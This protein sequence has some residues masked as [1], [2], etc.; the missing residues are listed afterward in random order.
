MVLPRVVCAIERT[1][2]PLKD[3]ARLAARIWLPA[4]AKH[5]PVPAILEYLSYR[6]RHSTFKRD[7]LTH[8]YLAGYGYAGV[9]VDIGGSGELDSLLSDEYT[10]QGQGDAPEIIAWLVEQSWCSGAV[11]T[12]GISWGEFNGVHHRGG[13]T[14]GGIRL[15]VILPDGDVPRPTPRALAISLLVPEVFTF[16]ICVFNRLLLYLD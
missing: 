15:G 8:P 1:L 10:K 6:R 4:D 16:H 9:R 3:G 5:S 14:Y 11:G 7:A 2:M 13:T 12:I